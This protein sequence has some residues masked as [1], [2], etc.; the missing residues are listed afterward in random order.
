MV[1][2][3]LAITPYF[4]KPVGSHNAKL[5]RSSLERY[6]KASLFECV[7]TEEYFLV[8]KLHFT[9]YLSGELHI[10]YIHKAK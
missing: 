2:C 7:V 9:F 6:L 3:I 8:G 5:W 10:S 4:S 1:E